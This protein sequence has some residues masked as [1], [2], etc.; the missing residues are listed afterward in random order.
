[1]HTEPFIYYF[2]F[3]VYYGLLC[4]RYFRKQRSPFLLN[5]NGEWIIVDKNPMNFLS[6]NLRCCRLSLQGTDMFWCRGRGKTGLSLWLSLHELWPQVGVSETFALR[7]A[8]HKSA[9]TYHESPEL[10][11]CNAQVY[12]PHCIN[13]PKG[14][15]ESTAMHTQLLMDMITLKSCPVVE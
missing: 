11:Y 10:D 4:K 14:P 7:G 2:S 13:R 1:M 3:G 8:F 5:G 6:S 15:K 9:M 12:Y